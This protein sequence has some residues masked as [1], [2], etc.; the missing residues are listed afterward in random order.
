IDKYPKRSYVFDYKSVLVEKWGLID[1]EHNILVLNKES[2]IIYNHTVEW[3]KEELL[4]LDSLI[5]SLVKS[6]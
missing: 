3:D 1:D 4:T 2:K 6:R 5:R